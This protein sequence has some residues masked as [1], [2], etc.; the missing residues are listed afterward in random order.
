MPAVT[1]WG[2][3][4]PVPDCPKGN[5][6]LKKKLT[7]EDAQ[8]SVVNHLISSPAHGMSKDDAEMSVLS[9][10]A[11]ASEVISVMPVVAYFA[12]TVVEPTGHL[13]EEVAS[14]KAF[15]A[16]G[17]LVQKL[18]FGACTGLQLQSALR[19]HLPLF[20]KAY[21]PEWVR[22]K[23]HFAMHIPLQIQRDTMLLDTF[24]HERKHKLVKGYADHHDSDVAF[25]KAVLTRCIIQQC[26]QLQEADRYADRLQ[27]SREQLPA[28][29]LHAFGA[30]RGHI[31][32]E[33]H[34]EHVT[35]SVGDLLV[36]KSGAVLILNACLE[37][38]GSL[39]MLVHNLVL[40]AV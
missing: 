3:W 5:R 16:V 21:G 39:K 12:E 32:P 18:K 29:L 17:V 38:D 22:P 31:A 13:Q 15:H 4:C 26:R 30:T 28:P 1:V 33:M 11:M 23:H 25:E 7:M 37:L 20:V 34:F 35:A 27:G 24:V 14:F 6:M 19:R 36:A 2:C 40:G 9:F 10:K 8:W